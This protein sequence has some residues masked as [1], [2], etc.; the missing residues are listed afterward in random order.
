MTTAK[1]QSIFALVLI[2]VALF[3]LYNVTQHMD[4]LHTGNMGILLNN[5]KFALSLGK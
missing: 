4:Q 5:A 1:F 2:V 3:V